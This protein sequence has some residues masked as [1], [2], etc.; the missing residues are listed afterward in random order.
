MRIV[1]YLILIK[2]QKAEFYNGTGDKAKI[3]RKRTGILFLINVTLKYRTIEP[4]K[5]IILL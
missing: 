2:A 5:S 1:R 3:T 4:E